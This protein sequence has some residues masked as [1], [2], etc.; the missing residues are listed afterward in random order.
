MCIYYRLCVGLLQFTEG[1]GHQMSGYNSHH[2]SVEAEECAGMEY[3][4]H[5]KHICREIF[6]RDSHR[7]EHG[8]VAV[9]HLAEK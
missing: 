3:V 7:C 6:D 1:C 8:N 5:I 4:Q 9:R 2:E